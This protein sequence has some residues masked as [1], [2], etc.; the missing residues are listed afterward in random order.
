[1]KKNKLKHQHGLQLDL[2]ALFCQTPLPPDIIRLGSPS[3]CDF[4]AE[5]KKAPRFTL[6]LETAESKE[7]NGLDFVRGEIRLFQILLPSGRLLILDAFKDFQDS[8]FKLEFLAILQETLANSKQLV[9]GQNLYFDLLWLKAKYG[10]N[11][12][13]VRDTKIMAQVLCAGIK[14]QRYSLGAIYQWLFKKTIAKEL[15]T[16]N[17]NLPDLS[18]DQLIYAANDVRYTEECYLE[19]RQRLNKYKDTLDVNGDV[20][21]RTLAEVAAVECDAIPGF[22]EIAFNGYPIDIPIAN[23]LI[24]DYE[25]AIADLYAPVSSRLNNLPYTAF[26]KD[27]ATAI[28]DY[29]GIWLLQEKTAHEL[30]RDKDNKDDDAITIQQFRLFGKTY[31]EI[32]KTHVL[33]TNSACLFAYFLETGNEDLLIIS[34]VRSLKKLK[35]TLINLRDSAVQ[36]N[37]RAMSRYNTLGNTGS[38]RST[39]SGDNKGT[40]ISLNLQNLPNP[41]EHSLLDKYKLKPIRYCIQAPPNRKLSIQDL[42]SSH[43]R[44]CAK[45]SGDRNL[46]AT[47]D[48]VDPHLTGT[49]ILI[50]TVTGSKLTLSDVKA[51]GGKKDKEI[52][53]FRSLFKTFFYLSLNVGGVKRLLT[54]LNKDFQTCSMEVAQACSVSFK[55]TFP[56]VVRWQKSLH[57]KASNTVIDIIVELKSGRK[58]TQQ[59][60]QFRVPDG[61]LFHAPLYETTDFNGNKVKQPKINDCTSVSLI[62]PE[63]LLQKQSMKEILELTISGLFSYECKFIGMV[64][65]EIVLELPDDPEGLEYARTVN[66][67]IAR[68]FQ[69]ALGD[70]PSGMGCTDKEVRDTLADNYSQK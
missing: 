46:L 59:Y 36:N 63:A 24:K 3:I 2:N 67:I 16:S 14:T 15:Q 42:S 12:R 10:F 34:L 51:R 57:K 25:N 61:R 17:W 70:I 35:D 69:L 33:T 30:A 39:S 37:G 7:G 4:F 6:D 9:V 31:P 49:T 68:N 22:V 47:L 8:R 40:T 23:Q 64:H 52:A 11:A 62:S 53:G 65:D 5:W 56:G 18:N 44:L 43:S 1:M 27:L 32:P 21:E 20:C 48:E 45:L 28:Y 66:Q 50:N 38:G 60:A 41:V 54:V 58:Y 19:L 13:W 26:A 55:E 29:H